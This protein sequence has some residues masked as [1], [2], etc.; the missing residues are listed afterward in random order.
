M[1][2]NPRLTCPSANHDNPTLLAR[3]GFTLNRLFSAVFRFFSKAGLRDNLPS[4]GYTT[5]SMH[6]IIS[7]SSLRGVLSCLAPGKS[8]GLGSERC[9]RVL[10]ATRHVS[11]WDIQPIP[12]RLQNTPIIETGR[13]AAA[14]LSVRASPPRLAHRYPLRRQVTVVWPTPLEE[15]IS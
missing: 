11:A 15:P 12:P 13:A 10:E 14:A 4:A 6:G 7:E 3:C 2:K 5:R 9:E 1:T 8:I